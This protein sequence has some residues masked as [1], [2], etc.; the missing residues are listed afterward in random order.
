[1]AKK[2]RSKIK[3]VT[4]KGGVTTK[5]KIKSVYNPKTK[6]QKIK[7]KVVTKS[8]GNRSVKRNRIKM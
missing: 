8:K 3:R 5:T 1:M 6:K 4:K 2:D 7:K